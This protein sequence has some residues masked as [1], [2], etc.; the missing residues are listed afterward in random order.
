MPSSIQSAPPLSRDRRIFKV[1]SRSG[2]PAVMKGIS[3]ASPRLFSSANFVSIRFNVS[4][5][6]VQKF[7]PVNQNPE[8]LN[9]QIIELTYLYAQIISHGHHV[10]VAAA[11]QIHDDKLVF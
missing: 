9:L 10:L 4:L 5:A 8:I 11:R 1:V 6:P 3:P 7:T 2:S